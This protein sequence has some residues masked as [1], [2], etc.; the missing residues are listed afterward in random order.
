MI[1]YSERVPNHEETAVTTTTSTRSGDVEAAN[2]TGL[3]VEELAALADSVRGVC[4]VV[5]PDATHAGS[6]DLG[7]LW[8]AAVEQGWTELGEPEL[9][10]AAVV[11]QRELGRVAA[12]LPIVDGH[13]A[14]IVLAAGGH[15]DALA[16]VATGPDRPVIAHASL[17]SGTGV[18]ARHVEAAAAATHLLVVDEDAGTVGW[19]DLSHAVI[20]P[21][22]GLAIPAWSEIRLDGDPL[23]T[24]PLADHPHLLRI[25]RLGLAARAA[26]AVER[27]H[28]LALAFA[29]HRRQ[30]GKII[31][32]FQAV[33]HRLVD[34]QLKTTAAQELLAHVYTLRAAGADAWVLACEI[35]LEFVTDHAATLQFEAHHT[36]AASGYFDE[37]EGPWLF[38]RVHADLATLSAIGRDA[39]VGEYLIDHGRRLPDYD[40]GSSAA[41]VREEVLEAFAP[42]ES[43]PPSHLHTWDDDA[44]A[45]LRDRG[46]IGVGWPSDVG[47]GGW[48]TGDVLAF[49]EAMAYTNPPLGNIMMG[50]NSIAPMAIKVASPALRDL[51]LSE[52]RGGDL[53][54]ALG[55][56]EPEAGSDLASLRTRA[57]RVEGGWRINGQ[58]MWGTCFPDSRWVVLA[59]RTDQDAARPQAGITLFLVDTDSPGITVSPHTSLAGDV[60]ATT[61]WDDVF[62]GD[63]RVIGEV[64]AGWT[65][66]TQALASER[67]LIGAS[68]MRA[69][70]A[71]DRL[72]D[73]IRRSPESILAGRR[74]SVR[75]EMSRLAVRLQAARSLVELAVRAMADGPGPAAPMA[76]VAATELA[77][78]LNATAV[79]LL[80]PDSLYEWGVAG[81]VGDGYFDSGLRS[82]I[83]SVIAG[84]TGDIQ[85]NLIARSIGL[86][87]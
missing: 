18:V 26:A 24:A 58:K 71:F 2:A 44:R 85:R 38:R 1:G 81:G 23:W 45:V 69:H 49:S 63:D 7:A 27:T 19:F 34:A 78:D 47:G 35:Y 43:G 5:W 64:N 75:H 12:P 67:V 21:L 50:I 82:S 8:D 86:P 48:D 20:E 30:F 76:K 16:A 42:W 77:E 65:A 51:V 73:L 36:L 59:A 25:R 70:R 17:T 60:S 29:Q 13:L 22:P 14:V 31:G 11:I 4:E 28:E 87:R 68:V 74:G 57:D 55:Y 61:F 84:G 62:V 37:S 83:M 33:S 46:W 10:P 79:A 41:A 72:I 32:S 15:S 52:V 6:G 53:S 66:L 54:I 3:D 80:G 9:L 56:S 40:R 39:S